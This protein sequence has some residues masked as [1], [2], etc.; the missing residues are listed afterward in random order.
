[1]ARH[2]T[3]DLALVDPA[4]E[5]HGNCD[6]GLLVPGMIVM[7]P[8]TG[9]TKG[10]PNPHHKHSCMSTTLSLSHLTNLTKP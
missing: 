1:M 8:G 10:I 5:L 9:R 2:G 6:R 3:V 4:P 7:R